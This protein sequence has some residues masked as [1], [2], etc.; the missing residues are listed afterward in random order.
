MMGKFI[1]HSMLFLLIF[2]TLIFLLIEGT[3]YVVYNNADFRLKTNPSYIVLGHSHPTYAFN[4]S[5]IKDFV[6][7]SQPGESYFNTYFKTK[8]IIESNPTVEVVFIE[9]S[10]NQIHEIMNDWTWVKEYMRFGFSRYSPF[11]DYSH[12]ALLAKHNVIGFLNSIA[13]AI[14]TNTQRIMTNDFEYIKDIGGHEYLDRSLPDS[15]MNSTAVA[16]SISD[17]LKVSHVNLIYLE[18]IV[19]YVKERGKQV[20][21]IRSPVHKKYP[22]YSNENL[23]QEIKNRKFSHIEYLDFTKFPLEQAEFADFGHLNHK[24][25][26]KFSS[27]F[28]N[29]LQN[30]LL[31]CNHKQVVVKK[32]IEDLIDKIEYENE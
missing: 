10:N 30:G 20:I 31:D 12:K 1:K 15:L 14:Q 9:F 3:E 27:W 18:K 26:A 13:W 32:E 22:Y 6:N 2:S 23:Y 29:L 24:G 25:A 28:S 17:P 11:M 16:D 19:N 5:L 21:L 8:Q 4:D 7:I